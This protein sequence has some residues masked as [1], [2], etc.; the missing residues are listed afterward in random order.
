MYLDA[1]LYCRWYWVTSGNI[2]LWVAPETC[3]IPE[4][5]LLKIEYF[6]NPDN[7]VLSLNRSNNYTLTDH[8]FLRQLFLTSFFWAFK[9]FVMKVQKLPLWDNEVLNINTIN[10]FS[11]NIFILPW[12]QSLQNVKS[13][14]RSDDERLGGGGGGGAHGAKNILA[15]IINIQIF[16][17]P[18]P[19]PDWARK[20]CSKMSSS[21]NED[22]CTSFVF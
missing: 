20:R 16:S 13:V 9:L 15:A 6:R 22:S 12:G 11:T 1:I 21:K 4:E 2:W 18:P 8:R 5:P 14:Q 7:F 3:N 17:P 19:S 10:P